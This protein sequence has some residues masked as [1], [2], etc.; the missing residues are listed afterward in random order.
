MSITQSLSTQSTKTPKVG[1][2]IL[3]LNKGKILLGQ[4]LNAHG[5]NTF[6]PPGGHLNFGETPQECTKRE[7]FEETSLKALKIKKGP[8]TNDIFENDKKHY[9]SIFMI[10]S[11]FEGNITLMEKDKCFNWKWYDFDNLPSP[12]FASFKSFLKDYSLK[13]LG[14]ENLKDR[15]I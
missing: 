9:I 13:N 7:L 6:A 10:V 5:E 4:R 3:V 1:V 8:W 12:L 15:D 14:N 2:G 11:E